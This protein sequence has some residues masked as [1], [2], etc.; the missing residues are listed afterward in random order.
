[1]TLCL[2]DRVLGSLLD[3]QAAEEGHDA[4][5]GG[6]VGG[7]GREEVDVSTDDVLSHVEVG[8]SLGTDALDANLEGTEAVELHGLAVLNLLAD[9]V[10]E[11]LD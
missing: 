8:H 4:L 3:L 6:A 1:M 9:D 10:D 2:R 11:R 5:T 7:A